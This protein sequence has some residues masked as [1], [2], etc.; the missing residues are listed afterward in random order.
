MLKPHLDTQD[1]EALF[2]RSTFSLPNE[3][4][5]RRFEKRSLQFLKRSAELG[6]APAL[7]ALGVCYAIGD[8]VLKDERQAAKYFKTA[9]SL[10]YA[11]AK[12]EHGRNLPYGAQGDAQQVEIGWRLIREAAVDDVQDASEF[13]HKFAR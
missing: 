10:G 1:A 13:M 3:E 5:E 7:Y 2:L 11:K 9:A 12:Y 4:S 8:L 6:Y